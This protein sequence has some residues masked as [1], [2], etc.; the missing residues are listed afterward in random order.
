MLT[1]LYLIRASHLNPVLQYMHSLSMPVESLLEQTDLSFALIANPNQFILQKKMW[2]LLELAAASKEMPH[3][4][5][6]FTEN[7]HLSQYG[8]FT[9]LLLKAGNLFQALQFLIHHINLHSNNNLLWLEE[10]EQSIWICRS[11]F[12]GHKGKCWQIE[13]HV[14]S[15]ICLLIDHYAGPKWSPKKVKMQNSECVGIQHSRFFNR[16]EVK[17]NYHYSAIAIDSELLKDRSL[18]NDLSSATSLERI[19]DDF[20]EGLKRL[21]KQNY[22]GQAW[23]AENIAANLETSVRTLKRK[24]QAQGTS[25]R[26]IFD[27]IRFQQACDLIKKDI[28]D[29]EELAEKLSYTHPNNFV[30][31]FKRWSGVTPREYIRLRNIELMQKNSIS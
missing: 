14:M 30:R 24:L 15:F 8:E 23:R 10:R 3:F 5:L 21:L 28:H 22:F 4:S 17:L 12:E 27:E 26:Q 29:Y 16:A 20:V 7:S 11:R 19:P 25:L 9:E 1:P 6:T 2:L 18:S 13:Q 31:A